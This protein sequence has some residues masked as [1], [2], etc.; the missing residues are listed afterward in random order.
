MYIKL[1]HLI[2]ISFLILSTHT[3]RAQLSEK[4][5]IA[6]RHLLN[7]DKPIIVN[8]EAVKSIRFE[9]KSPGNPMNIL[10]DS[11][12]PLTFDPTLPRI[13]KQDT[14]RLTLKPYNIFTEYYEDPIMKSDSLNVYMTWDVSPVSRS[15][16]PSFG[17]GLVFVFDAESTL[18]RIFWKSER[19]KRR[20]AKRSY[21][22]KYY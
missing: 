16:T 14:L 20:N 5:S 21:V 10:F 6:L 12:F 15:L 22:L 4:D 13:E 2:C 7:T 19:A 3:V 18:R 17:I 8:P 9:E 11:S 1:S